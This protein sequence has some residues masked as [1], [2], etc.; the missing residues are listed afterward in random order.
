MARR[1]ERVAGGEEAVMRVH[2]GAHEI[3]VEDHGEGIPVV[4][5][6]GF[7]LSSAIWTAVRPA[8]EQVARLITP[9]LRGFGGSDAPPGDYGMDALAD[10]VA[11]VADALGVE[12]M[13]VGG[14]SMGGYVGLAFAERFPERVSGLVLIASKAAADPPEGLAARDAAIETVKTLGAGAYL[15][16]FLPRLV[17]ASTMQRAPRLL[18]ELGAIA[19]GVPAHVLVACQEG[20]KGRR[21]CSSLLAGLAAP[22]LVIAGQE[23]PLA[24]PEVAR[25]VARLHPRAML[26][27]IPFAGHTP[28]VERPIPTADAIVGF[29][30][31]ELG[32]ANAASSPPA[33]RVDARGAD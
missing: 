20:M 3:E 12:R 32:A 25:E 28:S 11:R 23:D 2:A 15:Q 24:P 19:S 18:G 10:D 26:A 29:L 17:G 9:D 33:G 14:H 6:H 16:L 13:V 30:R 1:L 8:V 21:D 4:L 5:L 27:V 31:R 7:P 22:L